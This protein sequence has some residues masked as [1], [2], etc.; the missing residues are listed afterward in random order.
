MTLLID[1]EQEA[2]VGTKIVGNGRI[3]M[4]GRG[5]RFADMGRG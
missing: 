3:E 1:G 5:S 2:F 4:V